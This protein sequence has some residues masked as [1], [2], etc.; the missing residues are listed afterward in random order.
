MVLIVFELEWYYC[1][2]ISASFLLTMG[3]LN[4][5]FLK[6]Y[7]ENIGIKIDDNEEN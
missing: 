7:P 6:P 3:I 2:I 4:F 5:I 1:V